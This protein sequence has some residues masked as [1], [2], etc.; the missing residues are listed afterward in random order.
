MRCP[1]QPAGHEYGPGSKNESQPYQTI[2]AVRHKPALAPSH[3]H[4]GKEFAL[5]A[6]TAHLLIRS[7]EI[8]NLSHAQPH[9]D[10]TATPPDAL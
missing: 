8:K 7:A 9:L 1:T 4:G 6:K 2:S 5:F 10:R 3:E